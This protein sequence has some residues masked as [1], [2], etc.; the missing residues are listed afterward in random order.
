M[1]V[2]SLSYEE[3]LRDDKSVFAVIRALKI[4]GEA[5][6]HVPDE[7]RRKNPDVPWKELA[8]MRDILIHRC[9]GIDPGAV[10][11]VAKEEIPQFRHLLEE[12][13]E[14]YKDETG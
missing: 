13:L 1:F 12:I 10:W 2:A 6:K 9:F 8:G 4:I 7:F 11:T 5:A 3:F 14:E